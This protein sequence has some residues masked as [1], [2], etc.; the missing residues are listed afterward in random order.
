MTSSVRIPAIA[1]AKPYSAVPPA[2][3]AQIDL[4]I[5]VLVFVGCLSYLCIFRRFSSMEPDEGIVLQD[6]T[7]VLA[8]QV[9]YRDFFSFY[10]PGSFYLIA[11]LF[12][13]FGNSFAVARTSLAVA[14][15]LC[16]TITYILARRVCSR[17]ISLLSAVLATVVGTAFRFLVLHN[18]YS[19]LFACLAVLAAVKFVDRRTSGWAFAV[20]SFTA[21][22]FLVEQSKGGCLGVGLLTGLFLLRRSLGRLPLKAFAAGLI[23]PF[24]ITCGYFA[25]H[26]ATVQMFSSWLWPLHHYT[27]ANHVP[28]G[29]QDWS[30][31]KRA[32]IFS[33]GPIVAR[34]VKVVAVSPEFIV[35][36]LP[37]IAVA[38]LF[39]WSK[40][41]RK[42]HDADSE[43]VYYIITCSALAGL[44]LS[45]VV[46][47]SDILH[48]LYLAPLWYLV[49]AWILGAPAQS[50]L[51][52]RIR[53]MLIL[54]VATAFGVLG[55]AILLATTGANTRLETRRGIVV[56]SDRDTV[57]PYLQAHSKAGDAV[58]VY[59][60]L[61]LYN[62]LSATRSPSGFDFFQPG[63]NTDAQADEIVAALRSSEVHAVLFEPVFAEKIGQAWPETPVS[64]IVRDRVAD[65]IVRNFRSCKVL[66]SADDWQFEYMV[67]KDTEC[68]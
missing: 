57:I 14:G 39:Y 49:L 9:P 50:R 45:I 6:A 11:G 33:T 10:T 48:F 16:S 47:R 44:L 41:L 63:M 13:I 34:A 60:Y 22:T 54:Y 62:Y 65:Y 32:I 20:S 66:R 64:A 43:A 15:A 61:P 68:Q 19:T 40:Q 56:T 28:Y 27:T 26:H 21:L 17:G 52:L 23:W 67:R 37:L 46:A 18:Y 25:A 51:L 12:R 59:P 4:A 2:S 24:L 3:E 31:E 5:A 36:V 42:R 30:D 55:F 58:L 8:G 38:L 53:P 29:W 1:E 7:R 35:P